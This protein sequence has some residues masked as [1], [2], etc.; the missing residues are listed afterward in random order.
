MTEPNFRWK[1]FWQRGDSTRR[2]SKYC[3]P[4]LTEDDDFAAILLGVNLNQEAV[5]LGEFT[6]TVLRLAKFKDR[7]RQ[8][9]FDENGVQMYKDLAADVDT[10]IALV[11]RLRATL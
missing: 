2:S 8:L 4:E 10:W 3:S 9:R 7:I 1:C 6:L 5:I 11:N